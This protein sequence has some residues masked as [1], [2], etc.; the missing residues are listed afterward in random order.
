MP[1]KNHQ[2]KNIVASKLGSEYMALEEQYII[3]FPVEIAKKIRKMI[4]AD[5]L[6]KMTLLFKVENGSRYG[7]L[8]LENGEEHRVLLTDLPCVLETHKTLDKRNYYKS[9]DIGQMLIVQDQNDITNQQ[10][11][12]SLYHCYSGLTPGTKNI[13]KRKWRK[14]PEIPSQ[15]IKDSEAEIIRLQKGGVY[16][17]RA[18]IELIPV[19]DVDE[20]YETPSG[21]MLVTMRDGPPIRA[22]IPSTFQDS[23]LLLLPKHQRDRLKNTMTLEEEE[24]EEDEDEEDEE[25]IGDPEAEGDK[26]RRKLLILYHHHLHQEREIKN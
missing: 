7:V 13:R 21:N 26:K 9:G 10:P 1:P 17:D 23:E 12:N 24:D 25:D 16:T 11:Y 22:G 6:D 8:N 14:R 15:E 5:K 3:K 19:E 4:K 20:I 2:K 18:D